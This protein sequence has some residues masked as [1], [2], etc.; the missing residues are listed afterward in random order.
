MF[1]FTLG[2]R[3]MVQMDQPRVQTCMGI[4][5][6]MKITGAAAVPSREAFCKLGVKPC[7]SVQRR[8]ARVTA[9]NILR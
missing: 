4:K 9:R 2:L 1:G 7:Q 3:W 6:T 8:R 5:E